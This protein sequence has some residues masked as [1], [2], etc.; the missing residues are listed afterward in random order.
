MV[1]KR[2]FFSFD[3]PITSA[4]E[5]DLKFADGDNPYPIEWLISPQLAESRKVWKKFKVYAQGIK[6]GGA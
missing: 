3:T 5:M 2:V 4:S 1:T 6:V